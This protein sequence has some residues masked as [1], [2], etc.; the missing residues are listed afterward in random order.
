ME[1]SKNVLSKSVEKL[2]FDKTG[3]HINDSS[4]IRVDKIINE[5]GYDLVYNSTITAVEKYFFNTDES[6]EETLRKIP[7]ICFNIK[8]KRDNPEEHYTSLI[9]RLLDGKRLYYKR[10]EITDIVIDH[11]H[12]DDDM[13]SIKNII[14]SS[15]SYSKFIDKVVKRMGV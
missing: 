2:F 14:Y 8:R 10:A 9:C 1:S 7:G 4:M 11:V 13:R 6:A 5:F 15:T 12:N 3:Y